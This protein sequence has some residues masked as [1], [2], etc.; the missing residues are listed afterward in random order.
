MQCMQVGRSVWVC[1][2]SVFTLT[3]CWLISTLIQKQVH[4]SRCRGRELQAVVGKITLHTTVYRQ[5]DSV[6]ISGCS[7]LLIVVKFRSTFDQMDSFSCAKGCSMRSKAHLLLCV[8]M[9]LQLRIMR[10]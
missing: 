8:I 9:G 10:M 2:L 1:E 4:D 6:A 5:N 7:P 3:G